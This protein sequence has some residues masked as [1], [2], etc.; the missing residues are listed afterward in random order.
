MLRGVLRE[1]L[2]GVLRRW[3]DPSRIGCATSSL[4]TV[5]SRDLLLRRVR[6]LLVVLRWRW[7]WR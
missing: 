4:S 5:G 2:R 6:L 1:V 3:G 7:R